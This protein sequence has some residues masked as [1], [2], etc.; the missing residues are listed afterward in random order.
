M[1]R[2]DYNIKI[3]ELIRKCAE[4]NPDFRFNELLAKLGISSVD[5]SFREG[6]IHEVD[7]YEDSETTFNKI[8]Q[9]ITI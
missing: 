6:P 2:L 8:K 3:L 4:K 9:D 7:F 1:K 5:Y